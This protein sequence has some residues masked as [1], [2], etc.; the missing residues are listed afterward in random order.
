LH[1]RRVLQGAAALPSPRRWKPIML[2][3]HLALI[4]ARTVTDKGGTELPDGI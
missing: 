4:N 2:F 1:C 3:Y